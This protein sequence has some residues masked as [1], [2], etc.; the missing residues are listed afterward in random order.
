MTKFAFVAYYFYDEDGV[1]SLRS[2]V[3]SEVLE[4]RGNKLDIIT[5]KSFGSN[6]LNSKLKWS[7]KLFAHLMK[8]DY[9]KLY[10]SCGPFWHLR[11]ILLACLLRRKKFIVDFRDPW[12]VNLKNGFGG[13]KPKASDNI[14]KKAEFWEKLVY[15]YCESFWTVTSGMADAYEEVFGDQKKINV[16]INGHNITSVDDSKESNHNSDKLTFICMGKFIEYGEEK[17]VHAL[18]KLNETC[19]AG[20]KSYKLEFIGAKRDSIEPII[21]RLGMEKN[22]VFIPRLPYQEAVKRAK[23]AD[24]G[25]CILRDENLEHGT[26][27]FDYIGMGLPIFDC[28]EKGSMFHEFFKPY[29]TLTERKNIPSEVRETYYR[30]NIFKRHVEQLEK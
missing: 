9:D 3:L 1:A 11:V 18:R 24:I 14:I 5:R 20:K 23:S 15:K 30:K 13:S 22:V 19:K 16:V 26:K 4:Q 25:F 17:A 7:I 21:V 29:L 27:T 8:A 28:F 12:S 10:V 2:R 6:T